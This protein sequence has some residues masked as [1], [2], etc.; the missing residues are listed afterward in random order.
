MN[1]SKHAL[2]RMQ[3]RALPPDL[4]ELICNYGKR[5]SIGGGKVGYRIPRRVSNDWIRALRQLIHRC[6]KTNR[7][8]VVLDAEERLVVT[9]YKESQLQRSDMN[10]D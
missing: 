9:A 6:E 5:V 7:V 3:Q 10:V 8:L 4:I 2:V 1:Y